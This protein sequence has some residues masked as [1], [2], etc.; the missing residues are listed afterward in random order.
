M[1]SARNQRM[2]TKIV[3]ETRKRKGTD[4]ELKNGEQDCL[5]EFQDLQYD[6]FYKGL[7]G[8]RRPIIIQKVIKGKCTDVSNKNLGQKNKEQKPVKNFNVEKVTGQMDN[9]VTGVNTFHKELAK[10]PRKTDLS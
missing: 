8:K 2:K 6:T 4:L 1:T 7:F 9:D 10:T 5:M 3:L